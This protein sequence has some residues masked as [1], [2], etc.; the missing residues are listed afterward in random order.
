MTPPP[1][2]TEALPVSAWR[3]FVRGH[4]YDYPAR[5]RAT[6]QAIVATGAAALGWALWHAALR[7]SSDLAPLAL[8]LGLVA[9]A[10]ALSIKLPRTTYS[11]SVADVFV[12]GVLAAL[13][14]AAAALAAG[15]DG[16]VG[17]LR[18]SK[19]L[20]SRIATPA[21]AITAM[22]VCGW[23]FEQTKA[24]LTAP[25]LGLDAGLATLAALPLVALLP[26]VLTTMPLMAMMAAKR[27]APMAPIQW[28]ADSALV[29]AIYLAS[30]LVAGLVHL[31]AERF[32]Q[33]VL[34]VSALAALAILLLTRT[35]ILR[36][37][38]EHLRQEAKVAEVTREARLNQ[39]R[40]SAA[41]SHAAIGMVI[42][43]PGGFILQANEAFCELLLFE[44][45]G[46]VNQPFE[47]LL[48]GPD[49]SVL[50]GRA[51]VALQSA[52]DAFAMEMQLRRS[53]GEVIW[54]GVHCSQYEDPSGTGH[55]L[56]YQVQDIQARRQAEDRLHY[57]AYHD[58]LTNLANRHRFHERLARAIEQARQG[59]LQFAVLYLD[60]DRFKVVN[61]SLGHTAGNELLCEVAARLSACVRP[62]DLVARLGGDEFAVLAESLQDTRTGLRLAERVLNELG[63]PMQLVGT[64]VWPVASVGITFSD[65]GDRAVDEVLRDADLAMYE[66]KAGGRGRVVVFD[67]SIGERV[68]DKMA[69]ESDLRR[70]IG[71]GQLSVHF[72]PIYQLE[73]YRLSGFEA[74]ARWVHPQRGPVSPAVFIAM[75]EESGHIE[76]LTDWIIDAAMAQLA[77]WKETLP[78]AEGLG[79]HVNIS[80][81]D[82]A[83]ISL[84]SHVKQ[85]LQR[86]QAAAGSLTLEITETTLMGRLDVALRTMALL[87]AV[88]VGFSIDD[89]GTGFSSLAYLSR[90]PIDSL[91]ID[92][93]FV[94]AMHDKPQNVE[95]VKAI[96]TLAKSLGRKVIAEGIE[97]SDQ[98]ALLCGLGV[99]EGQGYLLSRP[100][101]AEQVPDLLFVTEAAA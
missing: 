32:G 100:L 52:D 29:A 97:T 31:S 80:G 5:A 71:E 94:M 92:R 3:R 55:C 56:I 89:F 61:D 66:A 77:R 50:Q 49:V 34:V 1:S 46:L 7:P 15:I 59:P 93:S 37:D 69:L 45:G 96:L 76:A 75:A 23:A 72:Q 70:A 67:S 58:D 54:V 91:K 86:H 8:G 14:P 101:R 42:V 20:S 22:T 4:L 84:V 83:R 40:F 82:L 2:P 65:H 17:T 21:A 16:M 81:R 19:R 11:L 99:Q 64:E 53:N 43:K 35:A 33:T 13:G 6:W 95:I 27:G 24:L 47:K 39:Q 90:L 36:Q 51:E 28:L 26:F 79:M 41:F 57:I 78:A 87:R 30:A 48:D 62:G 88:N 73:P 12:F 18:N 98:L 10:S 38:A 25:P 63:R 60:L 68:A 44:P 9:L 85:V 74:L